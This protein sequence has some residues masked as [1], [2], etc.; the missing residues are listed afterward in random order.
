M[1]VAIVF[2]SR[3]GTTRAAATAMGTVFEDQ[4]HECSVQPVADAD[5]AQV[6]EADLICIGSWTQGLFIVLQHPTKASMQFISRL[7]DIRGKKA[8]VFCTYKIATGSLLPRMA[9][10]LEAHG[11]QVVGQFKYRGPEL[12]DEFRSFAAAV[13]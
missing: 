6:S 4:G 9:A 12:T 5:P 13:L 1:K 7:G 11:A 10:A 3:T 2:D 8:A